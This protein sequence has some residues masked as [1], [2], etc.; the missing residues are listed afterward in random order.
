MNPLP[1]T[2]CRC[3]HR[4]TPPRMTTCTHASPQRMSSKLNKS[5]QSQGLN[6]TPVY[7][8]MVL[9]VRSPTTSGWSH[10]AESRRQLGR[11]A[12]C[13]S[14]DD[15][16][17]GKSGSPQLWREVS[18]PCGLHWEPVFAPQGDLYSFHFPR[19]FSSSHSHS[20]PPTLQILQLS[21]WKQ[22]WTAA[23]QSSLLFRVKEIKIFLLKILRTV[24]SRH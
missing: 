20:V 21:V 2:Q 15:S 14:E 7:S 4:H 9:Q 12:F 6:T 1:R 5:S 24:S 18:F 3:Q 11:T 22:L 16:R 23:G 10:K 8:L 19:G 13:S 17:V